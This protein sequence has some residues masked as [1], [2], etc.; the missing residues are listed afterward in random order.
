MPTSLA[1]FWGEEMWKLAAASDEDDG[2]SVYDGM[3]SRTTPAQK[4]GALDA[5]VARLTN[6]FGKW[7]TPWG[8]INRFQRLDG[9]IAPDHE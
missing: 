9:A 7:A 3:V 4:L 8:E 5:A 2:L 6:D 1:V